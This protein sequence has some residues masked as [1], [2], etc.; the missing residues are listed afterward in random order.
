[1]ARYTENVAVDKPFADAW[2]GVHGALVAYNWSIVTVRD[3]TFFVRERLSLTNMLWRN[4]CR[5][6]VHVRREDDT[7]TLIYLIGSTLGFGPLPKGRV[8]RATEILK[9]Q[10]LGALAQM[11]QASQAP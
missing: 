9:G 11:P 2:R 1:V 8:R 10:L 7:R 3:N 4:P 6:A 5:F